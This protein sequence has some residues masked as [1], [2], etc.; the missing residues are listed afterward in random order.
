MGE[1]S[2]RKKTDPL[3]GKVAQ[4]DR[5]K[6]IIVSPPIEID[7]SSIYARSS[8]LDDMELRLSLIHI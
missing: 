2:K 6:G 5:F 7:G 4:K 3:Y 8:N 1:A